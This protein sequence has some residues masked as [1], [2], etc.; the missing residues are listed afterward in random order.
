MYIVLYQ[1]YI[2]FGRKKE[3][4]M[5]NMLYSCLLLWF[6]VYVQFI[7]L[8]ILIIMNDYVWVKRRCDWRF[9]KLKEFNLL[10]VKK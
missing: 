6:L 8:F 1:F 4:E 7:I 5:F 9:V 3:K 2:V 10:V